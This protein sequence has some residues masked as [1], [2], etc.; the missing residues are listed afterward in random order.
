EEPHL[1]IDKAIY[2]AMLKKLGEFQKKR[3]SVIRSLDNSMI[4]KEIT[5]EKGEKMTLWWFLMRQVLEHEVYHRGQIAAYL[6]VLKGES[7]KF[8]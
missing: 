1:Q 6:K 3:H 8:K 2:Q 5:D 7:T 4:N